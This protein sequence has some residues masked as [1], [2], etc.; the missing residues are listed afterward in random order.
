MEGSEMKSLAATI[1]VLVALVASSWA[2]EN[3]TLYYIH[4][5]GDGTLVVSS[6]LFP[7]RFAVK[8][9]QKTAVVRLDG[10]A[11][12]LSDL[13]VGQWV[14]LYSR[15][16]GYDPENQWIAKIEVDSEPMKPVNERLAATAEV[17]VRGNV[18]ADP[19]SP[20]RGGGP[21]VTLTVSDVFK[22]PKDV[23]IDVSQTL[24]VKTTREFSGPV[25]LYLVFDREQGLYR[26]QDKEDLIHK[27]VGWMLREVGKRNQAVEEGFLADHAGDMPRTM[28]RYAIERFPERKRQMYLGF[29][30]CST[31]VRQ[32][33]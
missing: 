31:S 5:I 30:G 33:R 11:G 32:L 2:A 17:V 1:S 24:V 3:Y 25:T 10:K 23:R 14:K 8:T 19:A 26:L 7:D 13:K 16:G 6:C 28:L 15:D 29:G 21:T 12:N 4:S 20:E 22:T 18:A 9:D 27:A